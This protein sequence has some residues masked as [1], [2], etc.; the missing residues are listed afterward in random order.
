MEKM[1]TQMHETKAEKAWRRER[2]TAAARATENLTRL[3]QPANEQAAALATETVRNERAAAAGMDYA[4]TVDGVFTQAERAILDAEI[5]ARKDAIFA[6]T[7]DLQ[8][9]LGSIAARNAQHA[10]ARSSLTQDILFCVKVL[11][12]NY[13]VPSVNKIV[14]AMSSNAEREC[15]IG[16]IERLFGGVYADESGDH[17]FDRKSSIV[18][19]SKKDCKFSLTV[20]GK[21]PWEKVRRRDVAETALRL[22]FCYIDDITGITSIKP[23]RKEQS[24]TEKEFARR[25]A[26]MVKD[27]AKKGA[28]RDRLVDKLRDLLR[29][30]GYGDML[31]PKN[32]RIV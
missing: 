12:T 25:L 4:V 28:G 15:L 26:N 21:A 14:N 24:F 16:V 20:A 23:S 7:G 22:M 17:V 11:S 18:V 2:E 8:D 6:K 9:R 1:G 30:T 31:A 3:P 5:A 32:G 27:A 29:E 19:F 10:A 13:D